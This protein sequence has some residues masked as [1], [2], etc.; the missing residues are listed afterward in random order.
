MVNDPSCVETLPVGE[1]L[2][3][4]VDRP[5]VPLRTVELGTAA[6]LGVEGEPVVVVLLLSKPEEDAAGRVLGLV[7]FSR[8][9]V[10]EACVE[11]PDMAVPLLGVPV[12]GKDI[13]GVKVEPVLMLWVPRANDEVGLPL[14]APELITLVE[15]TAPVRFQD[16]GVLDVD[17]VLGL[18]MFESTSKVAEA[19]KA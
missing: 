15:D 6:A 1:T 4:L 12:V 3:V 14:A 19:P 10:D 16:I 13:A 8:L 18:L 2:G 11:I 7:E 5:A 9:K 17:V